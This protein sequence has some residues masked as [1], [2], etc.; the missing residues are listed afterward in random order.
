MAYAVFHH[1]KGKVKISM[2]KYVVKNQMQEIISLSEYS[3][4]G[5]LNLINDAKKLIPNGERSNTPAV[6]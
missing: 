2:V 4:T 1:H 5:L 3:L 6:L